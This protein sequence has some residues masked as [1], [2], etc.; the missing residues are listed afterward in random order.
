[1]EQALIG[2]HHSTPR[3]LIDNIETAPQRQKTMKKLLLLCSSALMMAV[4]SNAAT[5]NWGAQNAVGFADASGAALAQGDLVRLGYF[6]ISDSAVSTAV[7]AGDMSTLSSSWVSIAD[8]TIGTGFGVDG[9]FATTSTPTLSGGAF[10]HQIYLWALN[11]ATTGSATQQAIF[12]EP[13][14]SNSSWNLP[15][16][17]VAATTIDVGQAKTSLGGT[18]LAGSFQATNASLSTIW[19]SSAGAVQLQ[20]ISVAPEP[21][22]MLLIFAGAGVLLIRHRRR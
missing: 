17:N 10:G 12:Y 13:S 3:A 2:L 20:S 15:G 6:T 21:S 18:Y 14:G 5:I 9:F 11:A 7:A 4:A 19:G 1:M 16:T 22:R 8:S